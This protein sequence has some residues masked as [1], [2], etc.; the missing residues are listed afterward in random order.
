MDQLR[1][2]VFLTAKI[3]TL[4]ER[5]LA[6]ILKKHGLRGINPAQ[7]RIFFVLWREDGIS[8]KTLAGRT[9]LQ[10]STLTSM[11]DRLE[12]ND[13]VSRS[14]SGR[15]RRKV[16]VSLTKKSR[17]LQGAYMRIAKEKTGIFYGGFAEGEMEEFE[18][19]LTRILANLESAD[20]AGSRGEREAA[21]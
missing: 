18:N 12:K 15:D 7:G 13:Y 10:K 1:K 4:S 8:M 6:K 14:P 19:Y 2:G 5:I 11:L 17:A 20:K 21:G 9:S 3:H 16:I